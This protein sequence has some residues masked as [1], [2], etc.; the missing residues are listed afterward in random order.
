LEEAV[1]SSYSTETHP[2]LEFEIERLREQALLVWPKEVACLRRLDVTSATRVL[3]VGCGPGFITRELLLVFPDA[4]ITAIE[5]DPGLLAMAATS[6]LGTD[7]R[8]T[9]IQGD[10][11]EAPL[12]EESFDVV[13]V[14]MVLQHVPDP[15]SFLESVRR[16]LAPGGRLVVTD[17]DDRQWGFTD[18][19]IAGLEAMQRKRAALQA[20][21]GGNREIVGHLP[22]LLHQVGFG[23]LSIEAIAA[24]S[25]E[26]GLEPF[27]VQMDTARLG[28]MVREGVLSGEELRGLHAAKEAFLDSAEPFVMFLMFVVSAEK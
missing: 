6:R 18:P 3:E 27:L 10:V 25:A 13:L 2:D 21:L 17:I 15:V 5:L 24:S 16:A 23:Q 1:T 20:R 12:A 22:R 9:F 26:L 28:L 7:P 4:A 11:T 19:P 14:R 8:V